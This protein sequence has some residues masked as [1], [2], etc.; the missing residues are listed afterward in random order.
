M[1]SLT[2]GFVGRIDVP[3]MCG[4][5]RSNRLAHFLESVAFFSDV[6]FVDVHVSLV[7]KCL[8]CFALLQS[9]LEA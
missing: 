2:I 4:D 8:K 1:D 6:L 5:F 3:Q 9:K 7:E